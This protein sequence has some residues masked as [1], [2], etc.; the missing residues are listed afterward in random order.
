MLRKIFQRQEAKCQTG[1]CWGISWSILACFALALQSVEQNLAG[2]LYCSRL[3]QG[4]NMLG[5]QGLNS[6]KKHWPL[7]QGGPVEGK[8]TWLL[9]FLSTL[10]WFYLWL[11]W[12]LQFEFEFET[13]IFTKVHLCGLC[14]KAFWG[15]VY[16]LWLS[17]F[18]SW[19][20]MSSPSR[21]K[22]AIR[23]LLLWVVL[24]LWLNFVDHGYE[25]TE[26]RFFSL[27]TCWI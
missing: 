6:L 19:I 2:N 13:W 12:K 22:R 8:A 27:M 11:A 4:T 26:W 21:D 5:E 20:S 9:D 3:H 25:E 7:K 10:N 14:C 16:G 23:T 18:P 17:F 1:A 15:Q 24:D